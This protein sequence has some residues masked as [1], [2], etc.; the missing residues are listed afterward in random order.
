MRAETEKKARRVKRENDV[1]GLLLLLS[2]R[3]CFDFFV[4]R[5]FHVESVTEKCR[6]LEDKMPD[7]IINILKQK[8]FLQ[9]SFLVFTLTG[10]LV[11]S[12]IQRQ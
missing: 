4:P 6:N 2:V 10:E 5:F 8:A 12:L 9:C 3:A 11:F 7:L 1:F